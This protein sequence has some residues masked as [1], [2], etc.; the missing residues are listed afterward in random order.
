MNEIL[1]VQQK[2]IL[3]NLGLSQTQTKLYLSSLKYGLLSVLEL[4]KLTG[5]NRQQIYEDSEKLLAVGLYAITRKDGRKFIAAAPDKLAILG[6]KKL[7]ELQ[8]TLSQLSVIIPLLEGI[9]VPKKDKITVKYFEGSD[10]IKEAYEDELTAAQHTE[11]LS[12]AGLIEHVFGYFP[13]EYWNTWNKT[14][15]KSNSS[16]RMLCH[17]SKEAQSTAK[18]DKLYHRETRYL[19]H[20]PLKINMDV[21]NNTLLIVSFEDDFAI[22]IESRILADSYR[23]MFNA[24]WTTA[25]TFI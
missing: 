16:S 13:E 15:I 12:F 23:I 3:Q 19:N 6:N 14:F 10:K 17:Y 21:F 8:S 11:V 4:S 24:L 25:K 5:I 2:K 20:F 1:T 22:W 18:N 9:S 7:R